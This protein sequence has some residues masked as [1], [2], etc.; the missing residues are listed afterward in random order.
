MV[1][2]PLYSSLCKILLKIRGNIL[3]TKL[4]THKQGVEEEIYLG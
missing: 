2:K 1:I 3:I 4:V